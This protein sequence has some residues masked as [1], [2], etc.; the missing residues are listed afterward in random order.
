MSTTFLKNLS[1]AK[2]QIIWYNSDGFPRRIFMEFIA[3]IV[4]AF[5]VT[6]QNILKQ[7]FNEKGKG[8]PFFFSAITSFVAMLL[9]VAVNT[10]WYYGIELLLPSFLF[11]ITYASATVFPVFALMHGPLAKTTLINSFSLLIPTLYGIIFQGQ[12]NEDAA[13][14]LLITG[15]ILLF[16]SLFLVNY[17]KK[18]EGKITLKWVIFVVLAFLGNGLCSTVQTVKK[19]YYGNAG[20]NMFM[21]VALGMASLILL[22]ASLSMKEQRKYIGFTIKKGGIIALV[23]GFANGVTNLLTLYLNASNV[24]A[25]IIF[26][27]ISG[28]GL[29]LIF[30]Y[31]VFVKKEKFTIV[32]YIGYGIGITA[33]ILMNI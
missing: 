3:L 15:I 6:S 22:C 7:V 13:S 12:T 11:A 9:F 26:P 28:G 2:K 32:Q 16:C 29:I 25:S 30:L 27:V 4:S 21:I 23:C 5:G 8:S 14:P 10:D 33:L 19:D 31:A 24:P 18:D 20:N 1:V 17:Q